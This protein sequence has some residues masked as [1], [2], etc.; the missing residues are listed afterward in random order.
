MK[1]LKVYLERMKD[2]NAARAIL[3]VQSNLTA[4]G[5]GMLG[6]FQPRYHIEVVSWPA[7]QHL[8]LRFFFL[9]VLE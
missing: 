1:T 4:F 7:A 9:S 8:E 3:V 2:A 5:K 6:N